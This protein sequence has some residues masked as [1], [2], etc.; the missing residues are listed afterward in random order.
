M[1]GVGL[2]ATSIDPEVPDP[3]DLRRLLPARGCRGREEG[4][5]DH[6][7]DHGFVGL[8]RDVLFVLKIFRI[9]LFPRAP[10]KNK[11]PPGHGD[12]RRGRSMLSGTRSSNFLDYQVNDRSLAGWGCS[13]SELREVSIRARYHVPSEVSRVIIAEFPLDVGLVTDKVT[14]ATT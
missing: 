3:T 9:T 4:Q 2:I 14:L 11:R 7:N 1:L 12:G 5:G 8:R 10:Q 13:P 6:G